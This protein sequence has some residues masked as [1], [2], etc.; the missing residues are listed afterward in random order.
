MRAET[1]SVSFS[2]GVAV[3]LFGDHV[4]CAGV[5]SDLSDILFCEGVAGDLIV[6]LPLAH[7]RKIGYLCVAFQSLVIRCPA[8]WPLR[9]RSSAILGV[10]ATESCDEAE[11]AGPD[12]V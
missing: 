4:F 2:V 12:P 5:V 7:L 1:R 6:G 10:F 3:D 9:V 8:W 11:L